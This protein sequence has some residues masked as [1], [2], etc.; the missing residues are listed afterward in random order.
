MALIVLVLMHS[1]ETWLICCRQA[2]LLYCPTIGDTFFAHYTLRSSSR[3]R[4]STSFGLDFLNAL[5]G[6][7]G[8]MDVADCDDIV[9]HAIQDL[10]KSTGEDNRSP[11][12]R[13]CRGR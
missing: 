10:E 7:A 8:T 5:P 11:P 6:H 12:S 2:L 13:S 3:L 4:G 9:V 1:L